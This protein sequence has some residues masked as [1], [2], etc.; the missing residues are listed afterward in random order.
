MLHLEISLPGATRKA[1]HFVGDGEGS[2]EIIPK[3]HGGFYFMLVVERAGTAFMRA[4]VID[5]GIW[6]DFADAMVSLLERDDVK[7]RSFWIPRNEG[8]RF[9]RGD[10]KREAH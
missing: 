6:Q 8:Q 10:I 9:R 3:F 4:D 5:V 2:A 7:C 1:F